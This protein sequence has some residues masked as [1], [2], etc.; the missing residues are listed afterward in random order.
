MWVYFFS[1]GQKWLVNYCFANEN[2]KALNEK[3]LQSYMK[4]KN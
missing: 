2:E 1:V 3:L 4:I